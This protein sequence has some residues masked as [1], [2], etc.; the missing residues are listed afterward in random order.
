MP[1]IEVAAG[2]LSFQEFFAHQEKGFREWMSKVNGEYVHKAYCVYTPTGTGKTETLMVMAYLRGY[3]DVVVV[4]PPITHNRWREV[5][6]QLEMTVIPMSHAKFRQPDVRFHKT[7]PII[8]DE[9]HLLGG[10]QGVGF[11]KFTRLARGMTAPVL[12]GSATPNYN[13]A[14][15][16]YCVENVL[17]PVGTKGGYIAWLW[18]H[19]N[20]SP[21]PFGAIPIVQGF[22][23][24][25]SAV[26]YLASLKGVM[27]L[28]D[29]APDILIDI[30]MGLDLGHEFN[31][32]GFDRSRKRI[33]A[34]DM[35]RRHRSRYLQIVDT[36]RSRLQPHV[37][38]MLETVMGNAT[39]PILIFC[40]HAE[41]AK[42]VALEMEDSELS[43]AYIDGK[44][45]KEDKLRLV[46]EFK[47]GAF[48]V[49]IGTATMA[50]GTDGIDKV[51]DYMVILDDTDDASLR[52][53]L[54]G[55]ILPRGAAVAHR[56]K[57]AN[58]FVYF[59]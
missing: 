43:Y 21:N 7:T 34:S 38:D 48:E 24:F 5:G 30:P 22:K 51:C 13:D 4:A 44:T 32:L 36:S 57:Q 10:Q 14:E 15:R 54:V 28:K 1:T 2:Q 56:V 8:V 27:Y 50:T 25:P 20:V 31:D 3:E 41:I 6:R 35:E 11:K 12:I 45:K 55:R 26:E 42:V 9:Y 53:Q 47:E 16:C 52:R 37:Y 59:E 58:R 33:M 17:D 46:E 39:T 18:E 23:Q 19:C 29:T 49:L 40:A